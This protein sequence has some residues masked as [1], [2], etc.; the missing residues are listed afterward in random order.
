MK[1]KK[2][3]KRYIISYLSTKLLTI[4]IIWFILLNISTAIYEGNI[5]SGIFAL[6]LLFIFVKYVEILPY[7]KEE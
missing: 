3:S 5:L 4:T 2:K 7:Q 6:L 1:D